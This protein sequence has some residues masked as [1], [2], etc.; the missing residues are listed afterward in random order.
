MVFSFKIGHLPKV[1][2]RSDSALILLSISLKQ[3]LPIRRAY[4]DAL[5]VEK[6]WVINV[7]NIIKRHIGTDSPTTYCRVMTS[8]SWTIDSSFSNDLSQVIRSKAI[9][10]NFQLAFLT[11]FYSAPQKKSYWNR[12]ASVC[13]QRLRAVHCPE[14]IAWLVFIDLFWW[15]FSESVSQESKQSGKVDFESTQNLK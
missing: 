6:F 8:Q 4:V 1:L 14:I 15:S 7:K 5:W 13:D 9:G 2:S 10:C 11:C 12:S 3:Q